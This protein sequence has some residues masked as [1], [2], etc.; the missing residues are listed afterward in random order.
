[1]ADTAGQKL[2]AGTLKG[3]VV[4]INFWSLNCAPCK[5]E[6]PAIFA[7]QEHY[8]KDTAFRIVLVDLDQHLPADVAWFRSKGMALPVYKIAGPIPDGLFQGVLPTT[9]VLDKN[10]DVVF[11][12]Q[13]E[14]EYDSQD[15]LGLI[16]S[17][18]RR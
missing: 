3:K 16:D 17:L 18:L 11:F 4:F 10:G 2:N 1:M 5:A 12:R 15:F 6:M 14:G 13:E 8:K 7:L 9:A